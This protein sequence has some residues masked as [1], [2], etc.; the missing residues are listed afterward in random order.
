MLFKNVEN[1]EVL[2]F[3][4]C[5]HP[6]NLLKSFSWEIV[7]LKWKEPCP[8]GQASGCLSQHCHYWGMS[9]PANG[10]ISRSQFPTFN[11]RIGLKDLLGASHL[12]VF[13]DFHRMKIGY[14]YAIMLFSPGIF[15]KSIF[16]FMNFLTKDWHS[17]NT[18]INAQLSW[19][20]LWFSWQGFLDLWQFC[21]H[22]CEV[23]PLII[24]Y[25]MF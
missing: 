22:H 1:L 25:P 12:L 21:L 19:L 11:E 17:I 18:W 10:F 15:F 5:L 2:L 7:G 13:C 4:S 23:S 14:I 8:P 24:C 16:K 6:M 20:R 3:S 9:A